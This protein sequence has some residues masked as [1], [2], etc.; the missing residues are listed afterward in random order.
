[1]KGRKYDRGRNPAIT[2]LGSTL[3]EVHDMPGNY[4]LYY[5]L[6]E[7]GNDGEFQ[8]IVIGNKYDT[9]SSPT[10]AALSDSNMVVEI[11]NQGRNLYYSVGHLDGGVINWSP[12]GVKYDTGD[13]P[14]VA[15]TKSSVVVEVHTDGGNL[16]YRVGR[17]DVGTANI[18]WKGSNGQKYDTG[19]K[20]SLVITGKN[21]VIEIHE[22]RIFSGLY[23]SIGMLDPDNL[24]LT[25]LSIGNQ[26]DS[27]RNVSATVDMM[28]LVLAVHSGGV[29]NLYYRHGTL[30]ENYIAWH[31]NEDQKYDTGDHASLTCANGVVFECHSGGLL[32][33][34]QT[35]MLFNNVELVDITYGTAVE[36]IAEPF[37]NA[38]T[39]FDNSGPTSLQQVWEFEEIYTSTNTYSWET[40]THVGVSVSAKVG[41][42]GAGASVGTEASVNFTT[43]ETSTISDSFGWK[44]SQ[45]VD[46]PPKAGK[47]RYNATIFRKPT[48]IPFTA[49]F[50]RGHMQWQDSGKVV[51][52]H[53]EVYSKI[54]SVRP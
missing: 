53:G 25:W 48:T 4:N 32:N 36:S 49:T 16:Y 37:G 52:S 19:S 34:Y 7:V 31:A 45:T 28:G 9:G 43:G 6:F 13:N 11:H 29:G 3:I 40:T 50:K 18:Q 12:K 1:M 10:I 21:Q 47:V 23:Y 38:L 8:E 33:L 39:E 2:A 24:T 20:P 51:V 30:K 35:S 42:Q 44:M 27:G 15:V 46:V 26:Y 17:L 41:F 14:A 5:N 22:G 54:S